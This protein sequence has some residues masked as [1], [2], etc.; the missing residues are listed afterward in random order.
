MDI[1]ELYSIYGQFVVEFE[2]LQNKI[3]E[4]KKMISAELNKPKEIKQD[5]PKV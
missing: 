3:N 4:V 1:K 2:I 5:E